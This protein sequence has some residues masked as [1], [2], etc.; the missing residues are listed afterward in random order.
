M[1]TEHIWETFDNL[2]RTVHRQGRRVEELEAR[3]AALEAKLTETPEEKERKRLGYEPKI[4]ELMRGSVVFINGTHEVFGRLEGYATITEIPR[5]GAKDVMFSMTTPNMSCGGLMPKAFIDWPRT[6]Q[7][8]DRC[9][10]CKN[11]RYW[12]ADPIC[13]KVCPSPEYTEKI[14]SIQCQRCSTLIESDKGY[15]TDE[16]CV[17]SEH[18]QYCRAGWKGHP[19]AK[20]IYGG[21]L[22]CIC[23]K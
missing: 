6:L 17:F 15:C 18:Y 8:N 22:N 9:Q 11:P 3:I 20:K 1:S 10:K 12:H 13:A 21:T 23:Q 7:A 5:L 14:L 2:F 4:D 16:T 19:E